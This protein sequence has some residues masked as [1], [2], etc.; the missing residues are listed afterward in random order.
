MRRPILLRL[1]LVL[2]LVQTLRQ[3]RQGIRWTAHAATAELQ[4]MRVDHR[5]GHVFVPEQLLH[6]TDVVARL[7][8]VRRE[9]VPQGVRGVAGF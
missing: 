8:Q 4:H 1:V 2:V 9:G 6:R 3:L 7:Q 5:G